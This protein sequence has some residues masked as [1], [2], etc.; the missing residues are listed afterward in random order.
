M[1]HAPKPAKQLIIEARSVVCCPELPANTKSDTETL[2]TVDY[3]CE[4]G[5]LIQVVRVGASGG[6]DGRVAHFPSDPGCLWRGFQIV[7]LDVGDGVVGQVVMGNVCE[8]ILCG[9]RRSR[10]VHTRPEYT[11]LF[12][13]ALFLTVGLVH[14]G[15]DPLSNHHQSHSDRIVW[16]RV[17]AT[18]CIA[19]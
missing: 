4:D 10:A 18:W 8:A 16:L 3:A 7:Q 6:D 11:A 17:N 13:T 14:E 1:I 5:Y 9:L 15:N 19:G 2:R 12:Y